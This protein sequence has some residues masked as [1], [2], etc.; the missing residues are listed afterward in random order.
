[1]PFRVLSTEQVSLR[2]ACFTN[3]IEQRHNTVCIFDM[4]E[5][6]ASAGNSVILAHWA[7]WELPQPLNDRTIAVGS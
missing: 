7:A 3:D 5:Y 6:L 2:V 1:V 4:R